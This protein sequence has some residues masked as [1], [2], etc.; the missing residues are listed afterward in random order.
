MVFTPVSF[1]CSPVVIGRSG[2]KFQ[3]E[4][5]PISPN[6]FEIMHKGT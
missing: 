3:I 6:E 5:M 4:T 1:Y 2:M